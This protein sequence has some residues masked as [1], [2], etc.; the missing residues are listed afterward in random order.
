MAGLA[1]RV[2]P[3]DLSVQDRD[4][5]A[6]HE[7]PGVLGR[8]PAGQQREPADELTEDEVQVAQRH[9][10]STQLAQEIEHPRQQNQSLPPS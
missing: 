5:V 1:G 4:L 10:Q 3:G 9:L 8:M 7:D 2:W 6:Q